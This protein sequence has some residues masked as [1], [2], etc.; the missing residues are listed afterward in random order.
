[1]I[2]TLAAATELVQSCVLWIPT[3]VLGGFVNMEINGSSQQVDVYSWRFKLKALIIH[4]EDGDSIALRNAVI[5]PQYYTSQLRTSR[6]E[7]SPPCRTQIPSAFGR[8]ACALYL[9][10]NCNF[11]HMFLP[12]EAKQLS[13]LLRR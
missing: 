5:L 2:N 10:D 13:R 9:W 11:N 3:F 4:P 8:L 7:S 6:L 1:V 12:D